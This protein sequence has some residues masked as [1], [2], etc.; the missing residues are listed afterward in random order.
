MSLAGDSSLRLLTFD[1]NAQLGR[2]PENCGCWPPIR[3]A[4]VSSD[5]DAAASSISSRCCLYDHVPI[6]RLPTRAIISLSPSARS[7]QAGGWLR[8]APSTT[9]SESRSLGYLRIIYGG[10]SH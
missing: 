3:L 10:K 2:L 4:M 5:R 8:A 6:F 1:R 9:E 7:L